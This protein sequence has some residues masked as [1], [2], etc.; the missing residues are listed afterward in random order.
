M[1]LIANKNV[2]IKLYNIKFVTLNISFFSTI[3][4]IFLFLIIL[5][6]RFISNQTNIYGYEQICNLTGHVK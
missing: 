1:S 4:V 2:K 5:P 3:R 6:R